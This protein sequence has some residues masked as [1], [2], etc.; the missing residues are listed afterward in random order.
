[1]RGY[2]A[3]LERQRR[4]LEKDAAAQLSASLEQIRQ[5]GDRSR[6]ALAAD[7]GKE[8]RAV[9]R[10]SVPLFI[11]RRRFSFLNLLVEL[12]DVPFVQARR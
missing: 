4:Q 6:D 7:A 11:L 1:M 12:L 2:E 8:L 5:A 3:Q 10:E 9:A